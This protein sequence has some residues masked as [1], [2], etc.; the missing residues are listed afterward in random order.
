MTEEERAEYVKYR[1]SRAHETISELDILIQNKFWN[2]CANRLYY[3]CYYAESALL[4]QK[5]I[6][7]S[8]HSGLRQKF[9]Q[10]FVHTGLIPNDLGRH[11]S[12]L[13]EKRQKGDYDDFYNVDEATVLRLLEPSKRLI[14]RIEDLLNG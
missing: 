2:T 9:G 11:F 8:S 3:A 10:F 12:E 5:N 7:T 6:E 14:A 4:I 1:I 13:F